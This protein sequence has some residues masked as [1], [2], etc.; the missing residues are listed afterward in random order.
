MAGVTPNPLQQ[1]N[2]I[3]HRGTDG[4]LPALNPEIVLRNEAKMQHKQGFLERKPWTWLLYSLMLLA[5]VANLGL[6]STAQAQ[7][8]QVTVR[9]FIIQATWGCSDPLGVPDIFFRVF[10]DGQGQST[11]RDTIESDI[12]PFFVNRA[13]VQEVDFSK[14][15]IPI[16]IQQ[17]DDDPD[18]TDVCD[19]A[20]GDGTDLVLSLDLVTC[21][22]SGSVSGSCAT[23]IVALPHPPFRDDF[24]EFEITV[25]EPSR[26]PGLNVR[27]LHD[28]I[29]PQPGNQVTITADALDG[30]GN[31][32]VFSPIDNIEIWVDNA[33]RAATATTPGSL[34]AGQFSFDYTP[35][36]GATSILYRCRVFDGGGSVSSGWRRVQI[37]AP[38]PTNRAVPI[39]YTRPRRAAV[40]IVFIPNQGDETGQDFTGPGDPNFLAA[41][42]IVIAT[43]Y[44][45]ERIFLERQQALNFW[46]AQDTGSVNTSDPRACT[47]SG[48]SNWD[49]DYSFADTGAILQ[50]TLP[51]G[52]CAR[53][54]QRL[55]AASAALPRVLLHETGHS[56]FGLA[57]EHLGSPSY[58]E[59]NPFPNIYATL[60]RCQDDAGNLG[61]RSPASCVAFMPTIAGGVWYTSEPRVNDLMLDNRTPQAADIRRINWF[62]TQC[63]LPEPEC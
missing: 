15:T 35:P 57:D 39:V 18:A 52:G 22:I 20:P 48:P 29:W 25:E 62:F 41:V 32:I 60:L 10:I 12:S 7:G 2:P 23:A 11:V 5:M 28:P 55:F 44:Y 54:N 51:N 58:F 27:C 30:N 1:D 40:D 4:R 3:G 14:G 24:I 43:G 50:N 6:G 42:R 37:G 16:V 38:P 26:S 31:A 34:G 13:F 63:N 59:P 33:L 46:I 8:P 21:T 9:V 49:T 36:A 56:P 61:G 45:A 53:R 47:F 17:R 19:I